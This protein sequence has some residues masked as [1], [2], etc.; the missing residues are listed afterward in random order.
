VSDA[1]EHLRALLAACEADQVTVPRRWLLP[2]L[3]DNVGTEHAA[4][5]TPSRPDYT[6]RDLAERFGRSP[7][8][9]R[10]WLE[11]GQLE[12]YHFAGR[13]WRVTPEA[14]STFEARQRSA[15]TR[16]RRTSA[17][18][19]HSPSNLADWRKVKPRDPK[20]A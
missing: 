17:A 2:L 6:V 11:A 15:G 8:T 3:G 20:A 5:H 10:S 19:P 18:V 13:E 7:S 9:V 4:P 16:E 14:L 12:G 1:R